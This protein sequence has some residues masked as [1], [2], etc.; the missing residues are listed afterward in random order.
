MSSL[1]YT[2]LL[3]LWN[4]VFTAIVTKNALKDP[5]FIL[6]YKCCNKVLQLLMVRIPL[7]LD[8]SKA[9]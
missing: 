3:L 9:E 5:I 8:T 4:L 1:I 7:M 6:V 2:P